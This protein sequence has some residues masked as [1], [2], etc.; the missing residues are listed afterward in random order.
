[1]YFGKF[2]NK[3]EKSKD[4]KFVFFKFVPTW[5]RFTDWTAPEGKLIIA[6]D[7]R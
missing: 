3:L 1:V 2:P 5:W 7:S 4:P 6:S